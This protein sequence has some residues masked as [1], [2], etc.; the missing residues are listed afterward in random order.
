MTL[1][2]ILY[3]LGDTIGWDHCDY[4][5]GGDGGAYGI[6]DGRATIALTMAGDT[7]YWGTYAIDQSEID[8]LDTGTAPAG[9]TAPL[10]RAW[11]EAAA[12]VLP[13][14]A[15]VARVVAHLTA[16]RWTHERDGDT[17]ILRGGHAT[18]TITPAGE[19]IS[20]DPMARLYV[21]AG[22]SP[23]DYGVYPAA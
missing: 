12:I 22:Y 8:P 5:R 11:R 1:D 10:V 20:D 16:E 6:T 18:V 4:A 3:Q 15:R 21:H 14:E 23:E 13:H 17:H 7:I 2:D 19:V 9:D